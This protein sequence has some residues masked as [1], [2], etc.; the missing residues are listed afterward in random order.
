MKRV[1]F[2]L[3]ILLNI[4]GCLCL[5]Y[6]GYLFVSDSTIVDAPDAMIPMERWDRGG[7]VLTIGTIPLI[8][9]NALG[10]TCIPFKNNKKRMLFFIPSIVCIVLV[11]CYWIKSF[12]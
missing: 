3:L 4:C 7:F 9:A 8:V 1:F 11:V 5:T 2:W 10:Y 6:F 12:T